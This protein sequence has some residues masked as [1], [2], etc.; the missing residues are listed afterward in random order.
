ML[1]S[2]VSSEQA[3]TWPFL[4]LLNSMIT[5]T[6][7]DHYLFEKF[8][9]NHA[10]HGWGAVCQS[11]ALFNVEPRKKVDWL[12]MTSRLHKCASNMKFL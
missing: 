2:L 12:G 10:N 8:C 3:S 1:L 7:G 6:A 9:R 5:I 11:V 4:F